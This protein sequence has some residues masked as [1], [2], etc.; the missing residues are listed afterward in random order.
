MQKTAFL[1]YDGD[2][3]FCQLSL[4]WGIDNLPWFP[5]YVAFQK[6]NPTDFGLTQEQVRSQIFV[7]DSNRTFGGHRA[8][9]WILTHQPKPGAA[10]ALWRTF[11]HLINFF[12]PISAVAYRAVAANRHRLPGGS[13]TCKLEDNFDP[14]KLG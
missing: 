3:A 14:K 13:A 11:G 1:I 4:Q 9:A 7:V 2:C 6:I 5:P 10:S 12:S 8:G